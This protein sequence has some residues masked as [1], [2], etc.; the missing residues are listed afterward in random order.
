MAG[1]NIDIHQKYFKLWNKTIFLPIAAKYISE[2]KD[3][4]LRK[5]YFKLN[6]PKNISLQWWR[7]SWW[8]RRWGTTPGT[9]R[10]TAPRTRGWSRATAWRTTVRW[11]DQ[12][13]EFSNWN[14]DEEII[15]INP[16]PKVWHEGWGSVFSLL[17]VRLPR[18]EHCSGPISKCCYASSLMP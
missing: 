2:N 1:N 5:I 10:R 18:V 6:Q 16:T 8:A 14:W 11:S 13:N 15:Q 12:S 9:G 7:T 4:S 3:I 17:S